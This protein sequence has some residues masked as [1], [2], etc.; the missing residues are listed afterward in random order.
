[1]CITHCVSIIQ[2]L[3]FNL[4]VVPFALSAPYFLSVLSH[5]YNIETAR[6]TTTKVLASLG[7]AEHEQ[8]T[9]LDRSVAFLNTRHISAATSSAS[10]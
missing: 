9:C 1:M 10:A 5:V 6:C 4:D 2:E 7:T 8:L 3:E